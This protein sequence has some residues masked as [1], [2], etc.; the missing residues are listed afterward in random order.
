M[1]SNLFNVTDQDFEE[2]VLQSSL[3]VIVDF[4]A[5]WCP[6]CHALSPVFARLSEEYIG[7]LRFAKMDVDEQPDV[8]IALRVQAMPT[9]ILFRDGKEVSRVVG[10]HPA[11]LK[12]ILDR[13][14][15][16]LVAL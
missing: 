2:K 16:E 13:A 5:Q 10:P 15:S 4:T 7:K 9:L 3:P 14:L 6:P 1:H 11:R 12:Q 8:P